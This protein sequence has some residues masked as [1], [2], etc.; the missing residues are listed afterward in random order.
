MDYNSKK[1]DLWQQ[2]LIIGVNVYE[3]NIGFG[4]TL[5]AHYMHHYH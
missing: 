4:W 3:F 1:V 2:R 5:Y